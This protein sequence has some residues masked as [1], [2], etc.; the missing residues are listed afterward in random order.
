VRPTAEERLLGAGAHATGLVPIV[1]L[2]LLMMA[3]SGRRSAYVRHHAAQ[4]ADFQLTLLLLTIVTFGIGGIVYAV[5][6][7]LAMVAAVLALGGRP[8]AYPWALRVFGRRPRP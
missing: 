2:P 5:A 1:V 6:W 3:T 7:A 4:A 8:F